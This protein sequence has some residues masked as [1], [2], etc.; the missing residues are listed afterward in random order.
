[1]QHNPDYLLD[2]LSQDKPDAVVRRVITA[3]ESGG[4]YGNSALARE[5]RATRQDVS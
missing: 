2:D 1:M 5:I 3:L 4:V